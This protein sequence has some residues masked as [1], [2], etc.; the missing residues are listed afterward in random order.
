[1]MQG[2][3]VTWMPA[4]GPEQRGGTANVTVVVSD[5]EISSPI[6]SRFDVAVVLNQPSLLKFID[7]VRPG[8]TLIYDTAGISECPERSDIHIIGIDA[9]AQAAALN[10]AKVFNMVVLGALLSACPCVGASDVE[11]ALF[12][13]LPERHHSMI[14]LNME[15]LKA[16]AAMVE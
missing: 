12:K 10:N 7:R 5:E 9:M 1:M 8:G 15:A 16:G 2:R 13:T 6:V 3:E 14:P 11:R 4:Y